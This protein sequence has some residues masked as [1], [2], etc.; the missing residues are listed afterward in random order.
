MTYLDYMT[1]IKKNASIKR[2]KGIK[3]EMQML[4]K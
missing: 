3:I 1:E 2:E 4:D